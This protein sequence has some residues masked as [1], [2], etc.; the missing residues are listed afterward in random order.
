MIK[1]K[2][3]L[4]FHKNIKWFGQMVKHWHNV[5]SPSHDLRY[6]LELAMRF[7]GILSAILI[8]G[9]LLIKVM[10]NH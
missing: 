10:D 9:I 5:H 2:Y 8:D 6:K 1:S 3:I 4:V 7:H